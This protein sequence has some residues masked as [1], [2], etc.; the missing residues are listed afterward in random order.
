MRPCISAQSVAAGGT[1]DSG[2]STLEDFLSFEDMSSLVSDSVAFVPAAANIGEAKR[3]MEAQPKCTDAFVTETGV[4]T[5]PMLGWL[6]NVDGSWRYPG[7]NRTNSKRAWRRGVAPRPAGVIAVRLENSLII[8]EKSRLATKSERDMARF[9]NSL[10][11]C[12]L[13][14]VAGSLLAALVLISG[15]RAGFSWDAGE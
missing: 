12:R 5:E 10:I 2:K 11:D 9:Q 3:K 7:Q 15:V 14:R 1:F 6:T 13:L 4:K 8:L